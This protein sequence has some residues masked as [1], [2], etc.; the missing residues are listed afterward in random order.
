MDCFIVWNA[1]Y[2]HAMII[3]D[4]EVVNGF[5]GCLKAQFWLSVLASPEPNVSVTLIAEFII[6]WI[7]LACHVCRV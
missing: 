1:I 6:L 2:E 3:D 4:Y 5:L 7:G